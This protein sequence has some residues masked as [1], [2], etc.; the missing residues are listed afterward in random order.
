M[1]P[2]AGAPTRGT[3][4][5]SERPRGDGV[6]GRLP[7][8]SRTTRGPM[9]NRKRPHLPPSQFRSHLGSVSTRT[10]TPSLSATFALA[11]WRE[12]LHVQPVF[13][14]SRCTC[15]SDQSRPV[16]DGISFSRPKIRLPLEVSSPSLLYCLF[17][18]FSLIFVG[19]T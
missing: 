13:T 9:P 3:P 8:V 5:P 11:F 10:E 15:R 12:G 16:R 2:Q 6:P 19:E 1:A 4:G 17:Y 14:G 18:F 7:H